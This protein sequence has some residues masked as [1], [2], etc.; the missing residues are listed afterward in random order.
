[1]NQDALYG[2]A[3]LPAVG[4]QPPPK[5]LVAVKPLDVRRRGPDIGAGLYMTVFRLC[6]H[7]APSD[8]EPVVKIGQS[9]WVANRMSQF[10]D[11]ECEWIQYAH[12]LPGSTKETREDVEEKY[13]TY[14]KAYRLFPDLPRS[15]GGMAEMFRYDVLRAFNQWSEEPGR[16]ERDVTQNGW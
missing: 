9:Y 13:L 10:G 2:M 12:W 6:T 3:D 16:P 4:P 7:P 11:P 15:A 14:F 8:F 1:M 5:G